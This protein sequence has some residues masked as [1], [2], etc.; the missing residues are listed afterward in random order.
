[1]KASILSAGVIFL[2]S[3][4]GIPGLAQ[5]YPGRGGW[6][7]DGYHASTAGEG[8]AR[9]MADAIRSAGQYNLLS[10][11]AAI[12]MTQAQRQAVEN[13]QKWTET[14]FRMREI[15]EQYREK[16]RGPRPTREDWIR[17]AQMGKPDRLSP[18]ELD[19][20]SGTIHWPTLLRTDS[21]ARYR[22]EL[23]QLFAERAQTGSISSEGVVKASQVTRAMLADLKGRI[24]EV[25]TAEYLQSRK[26]LE[27]LAYE[28]QL[29][30]T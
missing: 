19:T 27:S 23:E 2:L 18:G 20:V 6:G 26:F 29:P 12:N 30:K 1:M 7:D 16:E 10:S 25:P 11:Q 13:Q 15:N 9:G 21:F 24:R 14:Y 28:S 4:N 22:G 3:L 17:Y 5:W 8:Y